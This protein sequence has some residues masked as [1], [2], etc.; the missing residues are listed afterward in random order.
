[1][2]ALA[3]SATLLLLGSGFATAADNGVYLG[4]SIGR[5]NVDVDEDL[6]F[7]LDSDDNGFKA[8]VGIRPLDFLGFEL[9][10]VDLGNPQDT[11]G[12]FDIE[13]DTSGIDAFVVGFL[14][15]PFMDLFAKAA[16]CRG[17]RRSASTACAWPTSR[18]RISPTAWARR[19]ASAA[20]RCAPNTS[21]SR[22]TISMMSTCCRSASPGLSCDPASVNRVFNNYTPATFLSRPCRNFPPGHFSNP[23]SVWNAPRFPP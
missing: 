13:A 16:W 12:G 11:V 10:Y 19:C 4:G 8:I 17:T 6:G 23:A 3:L 1:M 2:R 14:P 18:A 22:S 21:A 9:N 20:S 15:L 7:E 5:A